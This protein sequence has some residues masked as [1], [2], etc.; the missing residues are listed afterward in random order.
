MM[1]EYDGESFVNGFPKAKL[2]WD[3]T[4]MVRHFVTAVAGKPGLSEDERL[5]DQSFY[6]GRCEGEFE[7]GILT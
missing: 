4:L 2:S 7:N 1:Q 6:E 5:V 3:G